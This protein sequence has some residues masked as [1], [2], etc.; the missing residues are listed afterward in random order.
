MMGGSHGGGRPQGEREGAGGKDPEGSGK[1]APLNSKGRELVREFVVMPANG[2]PGDEHPLLK[3]V[4]QGAL[5]AALD[6]RA[7]EA[8]DP[9]GV[10]HDDQVVARNGD[11]VLRRDVAADEVQG[12]LAAAGLGDLRVG[13]LG[14]GNYRHGNGSRWGVGSPCIP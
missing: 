13:F 11:G 3:D 4:H 10:P 5:D 9:R 7:P 14:Q 6:F 8:P 2:E 12:G 1:V